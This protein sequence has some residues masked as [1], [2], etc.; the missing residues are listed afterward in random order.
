MPVG[1]LKVSA[2]GAYSRPACADMACASLPVNLLARDAPLL[3]SDSQSLRL[4]WREARQAESTGQARRKRVFPD[5]KLVTPSCTLA[6]ALVRKHCK[7]VLA[8]HEYAAADRT[9]S[10]CD[11]NSRSGGDRVGSAACRGRF[12]HWKGMAASVCGE[13][14]QPKGRCSVVIRQGIWIAGRPFP[15]TFRTTT[16]GGSDLL[17]LSGYPHLLGSSGGLYR[18]ARQI[19]QSS[20]DT[21]IGSSFGANPNSFDGVSADTAV[22]I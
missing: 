2:I 19:L 20:V 1:S 16:T 8:H 21:E 18:P 7:A 12:R 3:C 13:Q 22:E 4:R 17:Q 10:I 15:D 11:P 9:T 6:S 14:Q 5:P